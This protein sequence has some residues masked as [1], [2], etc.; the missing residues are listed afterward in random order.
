M[1][2][3]YN[4]L[5][6]AA[7]LGLLGEPRK[8]YSRGLENLTANCIIRGLTLVEVISPNVLP[9]FTTGLLNCA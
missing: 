1:R 4:P 9:K 7:R 8:F 6:D 2:I 3:V 5:A